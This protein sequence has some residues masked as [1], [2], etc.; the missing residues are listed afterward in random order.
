MNSRLL[1]LGELT[2]RRHKTPNPNVALTSTALVFPQQAVFD[3]AG[4]LWVSD[5]GANAV[6]VFT[7]AQLAAGGSQ[8]PTVTITANP[9]FSGPLGI[10]F[11]AN[12]ALWVANNARTTITGRNAQ[13]NHR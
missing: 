3:T 11:S 6:Y 10:T 13:P 4:N 12:G 1:Q 8:S 9:A 7:A 2:K 5:N